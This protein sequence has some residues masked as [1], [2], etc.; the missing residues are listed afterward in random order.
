MKKYLILFITLLIGLS[1]WIVYND[2]SHNELQNIREIEG[3]IAEPFII[4]NDL[5]LSSPEITIPILQDT[6]SQHG[7]NIFRSSQMAND[8]I[9]KFIYLSS[10]TR[11]WDEI[12]VRNDEVIVFGNRASVNIY[13][14]E[15]AFATLMVTGRY[16]A[17]L[18]YN[19][20]LEDFLETFVYNINVSFGFDFEVDTI[21]TVEEFLLGSASGGMIFHGMGIELLLLAILALITLII[22]IYYVASQGKKISIMKLN[23]FK[24]FT[25]WKQVVGKTVVS[26]AILLSGLSIAIGVVIGLI[27]HNHDFIQTVAIRQI[28]I[29][30]GIVTSSLLICLVIKRI[31]IGLGVKNKNNKK[32]IFA[33]NTLIKLGLTILVLV[34][35][36]DVWNQFMDIKEQEQAISSWAIGD[37]FGTFFPL[38]VGNDD[39]SAHDGAVPSEIAM[40]VDLYPILNE[41]GSIFINAKSFEEW[42]FENNGMG[43]GSINRLTVIDSWRKMRVNPNYLNAFPILDANGNVIDIPEDEERVI[44]LVPEHYQYAYDELMY[45][46]ADSRMMMISATR[47]WLRTEVSDEVENAEIYIIWTQSNQDIFSFNPEVFPENNNYI[48]DPVMQVVTLGNGVGA[49]REIILGG[50]ASDPIKVNLIN[51][52]LS[53]TVEYLNPILVELE[54]DDNLPHL[55]TLNES[56]L[57]RIAELRTLLNFLLGVIAVVAF[58]AVALSLQN[59]VLYFNQKRQKF[60]INRVFGTSFVKT[61]GAFIRYFVILWTLQIGASFI[62]M[63]LFDEEDT[64]AITVVLFFFL[65]DGFLS[66]IMIRHMERKNKMAVIKGEA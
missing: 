39:R 38:M 24:T 11:L 23:G 36:S 64:L 56:A 58:V 12:T 25:I 57:S 7:V 66:I 43:G 8:E 22:G 9:N 5:Y 2:F 40:Q 52:S 37:D 10:E 29:L 62:G 13:D 46:F 33:F 17:E 4:P 6:A 42:D 32:F 1:F 30:I 35:G 28:I 21:F 59:T 16:Y 51:G 19:V 45:F 14:L 27:F 47:G 48:V 63:T 60:I 44:F 26:S 34:L 18:P 61:Y 31:H 3:R 20:S 50:G 53:E 65:V 55:V 41:M 54:L 15:E 49:D